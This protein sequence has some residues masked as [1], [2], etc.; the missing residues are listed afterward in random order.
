[1]FSKPIIFI[2]GVP[3][4]ELTKIRD[5]QLVELAILYLA[6]G[7]FALTFKNVSLTDL[8]AISIFLSEFACSSITKTLIAQKRFDLVFLELHGP[9]NLGHTLKFDRISNSTG[10][11]GAFNAPPASHG[12]SPHV[13]GNI[14]YH[15][16]AD[17]P[18]TCTPS[19]PAPQ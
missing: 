14:P 11:V 7:L 9:F 15:H 5:S 17:M 8:Q 12:L 18:N 13:S 10:K 3:K 6:C 4:F 2:L 16:N 1:M 19:R